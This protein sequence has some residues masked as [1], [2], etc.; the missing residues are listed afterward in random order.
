LGVGRETLAIGGIGNHSV[1][2]GILGA[3]SIRNLVAGYIRL[4]LCIVAL[5]YFV[6]RW[7][8]GLGLVV[9]TGR[10]RRVLERTLGRLQVGR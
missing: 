6:Q 5:D 9:R 2:L 8:L 3:F 10:R 7:A 1:S 4:G